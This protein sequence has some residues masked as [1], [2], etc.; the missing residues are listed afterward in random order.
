MTQGFQES[1]WRI[2][3]KLKEVALERLCEQI[4]KKAVSISTSKKGSSHERYLKLYRHVKNRDRDI[5]RAF[6][7]HRRSIMIQ[8]LAAIHGLGLLTPE[9][10]ERF[11]PGTQETIEAIKGIF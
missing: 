7:D 11:S 5:A 6:N 3:K 10:M 2:F 9:E 4:L 8:Q 1:D